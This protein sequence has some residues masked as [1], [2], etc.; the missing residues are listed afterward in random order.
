MY[1]RPRA[2]DNEDHWSVHLEEKESRLPLE[3]KV[4]ERH[5]VV[6]EPEGKLSVSR[7]GRHTE[8]VSCKGELGQT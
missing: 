3:V 6:P 8:S 7:V 1:Y 2:H 4:N 5:R